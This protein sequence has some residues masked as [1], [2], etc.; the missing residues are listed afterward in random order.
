[1]LDAKLNCERQR[2]GAMNN[3]ILKTRN[4]FID[5]SI[6]E[7]ENFQFTSSSLKSVTLLAKDNNISVY[8]TDITVKEIKIR[9]TNAVMRTIEANKKFRKD[10]RILRNLRSHHY[11]NLMSDLNPNLINHELQE[12]L[13]KW[14]NDTQI[15]IISTEDVSTSDIFEQYFKGEPPF[16][17]GKKKSEFPDA[18]VLNALR[19]WAIT[20]VDSIYVISCDQ[21]MEKFCSDNQYLHYLENL[22]EFLDKIFTS[23]YNVTVFIMNM[24]S[25]NIVELEN[26]IELKFEKMSFWLDREDAE[27]FDI[28][29]NV[30]GVEIL[31]YSIIAIEGENTVL[32][33]PSKIDYEVIAEYGYY[34]KVEHDKNDKI[35]NRWVAVETQQKNSRT[36][37]IEAKVACLSS[38]TNKFEIL[39]VI[40]NNNVDICINVEE[41]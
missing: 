27:V 33:L 26:R 2:L 35:M 40:V 34:E 39:D 10:A 11:E 24:I 21:D 29:V 7:R 22:S 3:N 9:I 13:N 15:K 25:E 30:T 18:F 6:I 16:G 4:V 37:D 32:K 5:T 20:N 28:K 1:M 36:V 17:K 23:D 8:L 41:D 14:E 31:S 12:Q 19:Q 38:N